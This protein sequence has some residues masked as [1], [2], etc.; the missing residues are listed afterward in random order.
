MNGKIKVPQMKNRAGWR[1]APAGA[2]PVIIPFMRMAPVG[3]HAR[4]HDDLER[5]GR[6]AYGGQRQVAWMEIYA[7]EKANAVYGPDTWLPAETLAAC[8]D[9]LVSIKGLTTPV[10]GGITT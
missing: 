3:H 1:R 6:K 5:R 9:F 7:G 8:R 10:G 2:R 4:G